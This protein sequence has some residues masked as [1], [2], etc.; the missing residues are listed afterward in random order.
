MRS[1]EQASAR[2]VLLAPT[3][4]SAIMEAMGDLA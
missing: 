3:E 4:D 2:T 1:T